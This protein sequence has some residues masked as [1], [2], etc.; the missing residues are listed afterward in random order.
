MITRDTV[1]EKIL[2]LQRRKR[3]ATEAVIERDGFGGALVGL[4]MDEMSELL[5]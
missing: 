1:E 4:T 3:E 5:S 2:N